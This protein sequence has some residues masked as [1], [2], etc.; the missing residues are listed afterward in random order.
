M[1]IIC[2]C[3][4]DFCEPYHIVNLE[5]VMFVRTGL[6]FE[7]EIQNLTQTGSKNTPYESL[8]M[9]SYSLLAW[10]LRKCCAA[11]T[12][13]GAS[14]ATSRARGASARKAQS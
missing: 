13:V 1:F 9:S 7:H 2:A 3:I 4:V 12:V 10:R 11:S 14:S 6:P 5:C 8:C